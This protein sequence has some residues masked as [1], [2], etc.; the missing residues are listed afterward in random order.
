M[1]LFIDAVSCSDFSV[2]NEGMSNESWI[3]KELV[4]AWFEVLCKNLTQGTEKY[5]EN[6]IQHRL[7]F[8][9]RFKLVTFEIQVRDIITL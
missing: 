4:V 7:V 9:Q 5:L 2:W 6:L 3:G 1:V 8:W